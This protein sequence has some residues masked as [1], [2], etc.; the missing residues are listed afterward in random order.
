MRERARRKCV[1]PWITCCGRRCP[2]RFGVAFTVFMW[3]GIPL[4]VTAMFGLS[5][6]ML[7]LGVDDPVGRDSLW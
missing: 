3:I 1:W 7:W 5:D 2:C 4:L 6:L